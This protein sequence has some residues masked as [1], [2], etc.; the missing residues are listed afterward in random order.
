RQYWS[1]DLDAAPPYR[2]EDDYVERARELLDQA[3]AAAIRD[4]P[5]VAI[6]TSGGLD[7]SAI[8]ATAAR[9]GSAES[10]TCFTLVPPADARIDVG[11]FRYLDE[12]DKVRALGRMHPS[13]DLRFIAP[14]RAHPIIEDDTRL[15][16]RAGLPGL[17]PTHL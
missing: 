10:I 1:P 14:E 7:S 11:G 16:V 3:V 12:R 9:L 4:T 5:R 13:L 17:R 6:S 15:F 2:R 8:A